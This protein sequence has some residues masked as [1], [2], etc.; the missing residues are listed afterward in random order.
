MA[1]PTEAKIRKAQTDLDK[2]R[3]KAIAVG[4]SLKAMSV[5]PRGSDVEICKT[6]KQVAADLNAA[7][8]FLARA[9]R[10]LEAPGATLRNRRAKGI[11]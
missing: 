10:D 7:S 9:V 4:D 2:V 8:D 5:D 11:R 1:R 6:L 3:L